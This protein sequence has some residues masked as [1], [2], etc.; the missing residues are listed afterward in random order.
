M[1]IIIDRFFVD[2]GDYEITFNVKQKS[3]IT[4]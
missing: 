1:T 3:E 4:A 2:S